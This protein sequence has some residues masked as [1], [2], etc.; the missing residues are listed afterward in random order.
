MIQ[1]HPQ[2]EEGV[3]G[4]GV[5]PNQQ[6]FKSKRGA[7]YTHV[8]AMQEVFGLGGKMTSR[9]GSERRQGVAAIGSGSARQERKEGPVMDEPKAEAAPVVLAALALIAALWL[10]PRPTLAAESPET[11]SLPELGADIASTSVS[12]L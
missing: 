1:V 8:P 2:L 11:E 7:M 10:Y 12:G 4:H 6:M 5:L 3:T 9:V